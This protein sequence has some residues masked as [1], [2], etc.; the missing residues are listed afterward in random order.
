MEIKIRKTCLLLLWLLLFDF[1]L[2]CLS[3]L[4]IIDVIAINVPKVN[5]QRMGKIVLFLFLFLPSISASSLADWFALCSKL[6][7]PDA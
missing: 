4:E 5:K 6:V 7:E 1:V 2:I 3:V